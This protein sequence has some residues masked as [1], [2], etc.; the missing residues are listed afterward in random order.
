MA[1]DLKKLLSELNV[2]TVDPEKDRKNANDAISSATRNFVRFLGKGQD[3]GFHSALETLKVVIEQNKE[4]VDEKEINF[5]IN[6]AVSDNFSNFITSNCFPS[7]SGYK[8]PYVKLN[9]F[10]ESFSKV[11]NSIAE[12]TNYLSFVKFESERTVLYKLNYENFQK[13][14]KLNERF[15][16]SSS[17]SF[18]SMWRAFVQL[19]GVLGCSREPSHDVYTV[20]NDGNGYGMFM[21]DNLDT[22]DV[23]EAVEWMMESYIEGM[24]I[25]SSSGKFISNKPNYVNEKSNLL[26]IVPEFNLRMLSANIQP[27]G[28]TYTWGDNNGIMSDTFHFHDIKKNMK[29]I[30]D[31][32]NLNMIYSIGTSSLRDNHMTFYTMYRRFANANILTEIIDTCS[33]KMKSIDFVFDASFLGLMFDRL[34]SKKDVKLQ[35]PIFA[36]SE[37]KYIIEYVSNIAIANSYDLTPSGTMDET[38]MNFD[39]VRY[40]DR[41]G[42]GQLRY[43]VFADINRSCSVHP[44]AYELVKL[45]NFKVD[46]TFWRK[47]LKTIDT[48]SSI[49]CI[50]LISYLT[51]KRLEMVKDECKF[52]ENNSVQFDYIVDFGIKNIHLV[53]KRNLL[54]II[55]E[56]RSANEIKKLCTADA[57]FNKVVI[58]TVSDALKTVERDRDT[59]S[60][61]SYNFIK[62]LNAISHDDIAKITV[63]IINENTDPLSMGDSDNAKNGRR[64]IL[65]CKRTFKEITKGRLKNIEKFSMTYWSDDAMMV[66][67]H[68]M[69]VCMSFMIKN[70][71]STKIKDN[72]YEA[73]CSNYDSLS[74][75]NKLFIMFMFDKEI[76]EEFISETV[77][78]K[79]LNPDFVH[80]INSINTL[81]YLVEGED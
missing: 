19:S 38:G 31:L 3:Y 30:R 45:S 11:K 15:L 23:F 12:V 2:V 48:K 24:A 51:E 39:R 71:T 64:Y 20:N 56:C 32:S 58:S 13:F 76:S 75:T 67:V 41:V 4:Y 1:F 33:Q 7:V 27:I 73:I 6:A 14:I 52:Y 65:A 16:F 36:E 55:I 28:E 22:Q 53:D 50:N 9:D 49:A 72:L 46:H 78:E 5:L 35:S 59:N 26:K 29:L 68:N 54:N 25:V 66:P 74:T 57:E 81:Q 77:M 60:T 8:H 44:N 80:E 43:I 10:N 21:G 42:D 40:L 18:D 70:S 79:M 47:V 61:R 62:L 69:F 37:Y 63:D 17:V 34:F